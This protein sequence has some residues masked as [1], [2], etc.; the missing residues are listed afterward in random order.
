[1]RS[2]EFRMT[3]MSG[4]F[5]CN[6]SFIVSINVF[7]LSGFDLSVPKSVH[8]VDAAL[9]NPKNAWKDPAA[10]EENLHKLIEQFIENFKKFKVSDE[11]L[12]AGPSL[13]NA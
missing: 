10:Y 8:G 1:M 3:R 6:F 5:E 13:V 11:I 4:F 12:E 2:S 9:L 7:T